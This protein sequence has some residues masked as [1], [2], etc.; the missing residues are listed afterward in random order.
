VSFTIRNAGNEAHE[1]QIVEGETTAGLIENIGAGATEG[2]SV[3][4]AAG[5]YELICTLNGH[6][7]LGMKGTLTV[8]GG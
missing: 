8:T 6:D 3:T 7:Q 4:L 2:L 1:F 5:S